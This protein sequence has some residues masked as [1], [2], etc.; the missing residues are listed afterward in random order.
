MS[1][2]SVALLMPALEFHHR[3]SL[4]Q[5]R[6]GSAG[7]VRIQIC[8]NFNLYLITTYL[9][10]IIQ[11]KSGTGKTAAFAIVAME[12]ILKDPEMAPQVLILTPTREISVQIQQVCNTLGGKIQG[13]KHNSKPNPDS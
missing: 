7:L 2:L 13:K 11:A 4:N 1:M 5:S 12:T 3:Y 6:W 8:P 9:D 10:L